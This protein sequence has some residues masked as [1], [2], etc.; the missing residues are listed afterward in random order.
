MR[1]SSIA[2][3][4]DHAEPYRLSIE[5]V[6]RHHA[7]VRSPGPDNEARCHR[8]EH[9]ERMGVLE[10]AAVTATWPVRT[11]VRTIRPGATRSASRRSGV[12]LASSP[13][14]GVLDAAHVDAVH[15]HR[16]HATAMPH[17]FRAGMFAEQFRRPGVGKIPPTQRRPR[18]SA[19][20][21][22]ERIVHA[23]HRKD[24]LR[25]GCPTARPMPWRTALRSRHVVAVSASRL[26]FPAP[27][28][29]R[30]P[31]SSGAPAPSAHH[32]PRR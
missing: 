30:A 16:Q 1:I 29:D 27:R 7:Q 32:P 21:P 8:P 13:R 15:A 19:E 26:T 5:E 3:E 6:G 17:G 22:G 12:R 14:E 24:N 18:G 4:P 10:Q 31:M 20:H 28:P 11:H 25:G 23:G 9:P 2:C